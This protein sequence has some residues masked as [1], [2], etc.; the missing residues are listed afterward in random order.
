MEMTSFPAFR[1]PGVRRFSPPVGQAGAARNTRSKHPQWKLRAVKVQHR[2][3][4]KLAKEMTAT[5]NEL[6]SL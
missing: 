3:P 2:H 4:Q 6:K 5:T 1:C